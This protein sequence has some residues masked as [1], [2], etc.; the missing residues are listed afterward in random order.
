M[1]SSLEFISLSLQTFAPI[2]ARKS[3]F[4]LLPI[5]IYLLNIL[6]S[7]ALNLKVI[8]DPR[9]VIPPE[10]LCSKHN[11]AVTSKASRTTAAIQHVFQLRFCDFLWPAFHAYVIPILSVLQSPLKKNAWKQ[12]DVNFFNSLYY[13]ITPIMIV[14]VNSILHLLLTAKLYSADMIF[15]HKALHIIRLIAHL[16]IS[17]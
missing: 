7:K 14:F 16:L 11:P 17:V 6:Q 13:S 9:S 1:K 12:F 3:P 10:G 8:K 2:T 4:N 5:K 15:T